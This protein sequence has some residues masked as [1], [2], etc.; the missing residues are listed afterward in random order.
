[1]LK[2]ITLC[3]QFPHNEKFIK[4]CLKHLS[5]TCLSEQ[6]NK[7]SS[8]KA[9]FFPCSLY[10]FNTSCGKTI[11]FCS[12]AK[13]Q[14]KRKNNIYENSF[15]HSAFANAIKITQNRFFNN[16]NYEKFMEFVSNMKLNSLWRIF[17]LLF[18]W[19]W[20]NFSVFRARQFLI[21]VFWVR[22]FQIHLIS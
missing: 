7:E 10:T 9:I 14:L 18:Q 12:V 6:H 4:K 8:F 13:Q 5:P 3:A 19:K 22:I 16:K 20:N 15:S 1:M 2:G 17:F 21:W 11:F